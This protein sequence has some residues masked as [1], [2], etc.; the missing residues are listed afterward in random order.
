M[1]D[2]YIEHE[3]EYQLT[4]KALKLIEEF[5]FPLFLLTKSSL[6]LKDIDIID[7]I[8]KQNYACIGFTV[9]TANDKLAS[10]IE[11]WCT[12]LSERFKAMLIFSSLGIKSTICVVF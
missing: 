12:L 8:S 3:K 4:R 7:R 5:R 9:T 11:S 6:V 1:S 2:P 10:K